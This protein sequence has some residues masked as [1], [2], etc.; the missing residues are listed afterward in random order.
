HLHRGRIAHA[1]SPGLS[2]VRNAQTGE[3]LMTPGAL[4]LLAVFL[5]AALLCVKPLGLYVANVME[6][7]AIWPVRAG[8]RVEARIYRL[9]GVDPALEMSWKQYAVAFILFNA[10]GALLVYLLQ[11]LQGSLPLNPQRF[12]GVSADSAFN[13]AVSFVSNTNWQG[14]SG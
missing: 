1:R 4:A 11:R 6:G 12:P 8:A 10:L 2:P 9:C 3:I 14:Y 5:A 13:T 7:H